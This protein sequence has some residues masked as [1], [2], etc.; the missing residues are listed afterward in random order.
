MDATRTRRT[1]DTVRL[2][3]YAG[4][5]TRRF[6]RHMGFAPTSQG[7]LSGAYNP[8][9]AAMRVRDVMTHGAECVA[10]SASLQEAARKMKN[11]D[12]GPL[13]VCE[14]DRLVGMI[15][16]RDITVRGTAE[17]CDPRTTR[18]R[19]VLTPDV[20]YCF[21]NQDVKDAARLMAENQ[22]RRLVVLNEAKRLVG[23]VSLGD[24]ALESGDAGLSAR[25]LEDVSLP[26]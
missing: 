3:W 10:P 11:L 9:R 13:P 15:T 8:G 23:I 14:G 7:T 5:R 17:G 22:V 4:W 20:V 18:V 21:E 26:L 16:D 12:V 2:R 1:Q 6:A 25:T 19:D 24:L